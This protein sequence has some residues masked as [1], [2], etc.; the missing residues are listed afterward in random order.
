MSADR[1]FSSPSPR[2][3]TLPPAAPF[4]TELA[5]GLTEALNL[6]WRRHGIQVQDLMPPFVNTPMVT[7]QTYR[8]PVLER[9]GVKLSA[10]DI[11]RA[12][13]QALESQRV[14]TPV[15]L[16]FRVTVLLEKLAPR[17]VTRE[18]LRHLSR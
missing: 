8:A 12:A 13:E 6:E 18:I 1:L 3:F 4:L 17:W 14:H 2:V 10:E 7:G 11:A 9:M 16:P 15:G 5:R